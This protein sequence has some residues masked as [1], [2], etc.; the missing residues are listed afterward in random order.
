MSNTFVELPLDN[1]LCGYIFILP[2]R[3]PEVK[4]NPEQIEVQSFRKE[5]F[6]TLRAEKIPTKRLGTRVFVGVPCII[7]FYVVKTKPSQIQN[8]DFSIIP[9]SDVN[10]EIADLLNTSTP[11]K[12]LRFKCQE[13]NQ[14][15]F[16]FMIKSDA[17]GFIQIT[18]KG[19]TYIDQRRV[20]FA[21]KFGIESMVPFH[22]SSKARHMN[23]LNYMIELSLTNLMPFP[24]SEVCYSFHANA[25][26]PHELPKSL[27]A[28]SIG[29]LVTTKKLIPIEGVPEGSV[30]KKFGKFTVYWKIPGSREFVAGIADEPA[31]DHFAEVPDYVAIKVVSKPENVTLNEPFEFTI[32]GTNVSPADLT[33][34]TIVLCGNGVAPVSQN[35]EST[36]VC[37][38]ETFLISFKVVA[39]REGLVQ[40]PNIKFVLNNSAAFIYRPSTGVIVRSAE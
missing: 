17:D 9:E 16:P 20:N 8:F 3:S 39:I 4:I 15:T 23:G 28:Q 36:S 25:T 31:L 26:S 27:F 22:A 24:L 14:M 12:E 1:H 32:E 35:T 11:Q 6:L 34:T 40:L 2:T 37:Q 30:P 33:F 38:L 5:D 29:S 13:I 7:L 21:K 10:V 18:I 19:T